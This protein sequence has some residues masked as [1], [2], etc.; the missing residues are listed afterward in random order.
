MAQHDG[1]L[2]GL[3]AQLDRLFSTIP[4][5]DGRGLWTN[6]EAAAAMTR[7]GVQTSAAYLSQ[8]R[9]GK[10]DNPSARHLAAVAQLFEVPVDYFFNAEVALKIDAD[11]A[12][13]VAFRDAGVHQIALR[14]HGLSPE[15][16][17]TVGQMVDYIRQ[18]E[19]RAS[20]AVSD[21]SPGEPHDA[22]GTGSSG[23]QPV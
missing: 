14:A 17:A 22:S 16:L 19:Q 18:H 12:L 8:L 5:P 20:G 2:S 9:T 11:L 3:V 4:R 7:G 6:E 13:V 10:R 1:G 21:G 15:G 23:Q